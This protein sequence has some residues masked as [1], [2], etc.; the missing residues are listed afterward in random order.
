MAKIQENDSGF[1]WKEW[2]SEFKGVVGEMT[3]EEW[4]MLH[5]SLTQMEEQEEGIFAE[6]KKHSD[7]I[8]SE[9]T[10]NK[11]KTI[12]ITVVE[13]KTENRPNDND[14]VGVEEKEYT[15]YDLFNLLNELQTVMDKGFD[16]IN[17]R[18]DE[19][20]KKW[21]GDRYQLKESTE[22]ELSLI[23]I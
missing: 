3:D 20:D 14:S 15:E 17:K 6:I 18:F 2:E 13:N 9:V 11:G 21:E 22:V 1:V 4:G 19:R 23:H 10:S 16:R 7:D 12:E 5:D 8:D